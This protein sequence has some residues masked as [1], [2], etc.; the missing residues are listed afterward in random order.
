MCIILQSRLCGSWCLVGASHHRDRLHGGPGPVSY[1]GWVFAET[2][3][4]LLSSRTRARI[5]LSSTSRAP[6]L[7]PA[8]RSS[9]AFKICCVPASVLVPDSVLVGSCPASCLRSLVL[10]RVLV[11]GSWL[12]LVH[13]GYPGLARCSL[14]GRAPGFARPARLCPDLFVN[15]STQLAQVRY[16]LHSFRFVLLLT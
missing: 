13:S 16:V 9:Q 6:T 4:N 11:F 7:K 5:R 2:E 14:F 12:A 8:P 1:H 10:A 15:A 3:A